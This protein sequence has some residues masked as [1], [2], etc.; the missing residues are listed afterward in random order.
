MLSHS[1]IERRNDAGMTLVETMIALGIFMVV[2]MAVGAFQ[3]SIFSNQKAVSGSLQTAQDAQIILKTMLTELRAASPG[4]N[5]SYPI[6]SAGTSSITF[7]SDANNDG[8]TEQI[9]YRLS[10]STV[11]RTMIP[12]TGSPATY[13]IANQTTSVIMNNVRNSASSPVFQYFDQN[14]TGT[15]S[16]LAMPVNIS[17]VRLV[18]INLTLDVN[19]NL[20]QV[21]RTYTVQA[22]LRNIKTN[23]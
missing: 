3:V 11:Y 19:P 16:P 15:S 18:Q 2:I 17:S 13:N 12:P 22:S 1:K 8:M 23:L 20:S 14:Y 7:F 5:G 21:P 9:G 10:S 4:M 6:A